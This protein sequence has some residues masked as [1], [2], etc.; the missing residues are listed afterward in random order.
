[1]Y[2]SEISHLPLHEQV[3]RFLVGNAFIETITSYS[4]NY[5]GMSKTYASSLRYSGRNPSKWAWL[6]LHRKLQALLSS[7]ISEEAKSSIEGFLLQIDEK[8]AF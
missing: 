8:I 3:Y 6:T 7:D 1:M 4:F 2:L 5:L